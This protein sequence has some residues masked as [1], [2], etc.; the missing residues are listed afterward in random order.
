MPSLTE[1]IVL[2]M[3]QT[4]WITIWTRS[5]HHDTPDTAILIDPA[6]LSHSNV[7]LDNNLW[8]YMGVYIGLSIMTCAIGTLRYL[9]LSVGSLRASRRLFEEFLFAVLRAPLHWFDTVPVG[10]ILNRFTTDF[11]VIDSRLSNDLGF[12][13]YNILQV[14]GVVLAALSASLWMITIAVVLLIVFIY[15]AS[16]YLIGAREIKRLESNGRSPIFEQFGSTLSGVA[17]IRAFD[18]PLMYLERMHSRI[19]THSRAS[20]HLW[21]FNRWMAFRLNMVGALFATVMAALIVG[22]GGIDASAAGF[23]LSFALQYTK[24]E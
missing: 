10:R 19:D 12:L 24:Y 18:F 11:D 3:T 17:T 9:L 13:L 22:L 2:T 8:F 23:A 15:Y 20:W 4:W 5:F 21:L 14:V 1:R 6:I 16:R 7:P